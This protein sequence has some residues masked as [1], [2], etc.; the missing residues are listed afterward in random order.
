MAASGTRPR[1]VKLVTPT[2]LSSHLPGVA[3]AW[4]IMILSC[5][6]GC[7]E[8]TERTLP[9]AVT[10][11]E[12]T[13]VQ[14]EA[15]HVSVRSHP[16]HQGW[17]IHAVQPTIHHLRVLREAESTRVR[18]H[19][20]PLALPAGLFACP[21]SAWG[22][23]FSVLA[24]LSPVQHRKALLDYTITSCLMALMVVKSEPTIHTDTSLVEQREEHKDGPFLGGRAMLAWHGD[25]MIAVSYPIEEGKAVIRLRHLVTALR[26]A[27]IPEASWDNG[28]VDITVRHHD[29]LVRQWPV[30]TRLS[31]SVLR[32]PMVIRPDRWPTSPVFTVKIE[33][34]TAIPQADIEDRLRHALLRMG[35]TAIGSQSMTSLLRREL[36]EGLSG[37]VDD[38]TA[39]SPGHWLAPNVL[40]TMAAT[41]NDRATSVSLTLTKIQN[42]E[43]LGMIHVPAGPDDLSLA[44]DVAVAGLESML[45]EAKLVRP[46]SPTPSQR[47][48]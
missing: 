12:E 38:Q 24:P 5:L 46:G 34:G 33:Q 45:T 3:A 44:I 25:E 15:A 10:R 20:N 40:V 30:K 17:T 29:A 35:L 32:G 37:L 19:L 43:V 6:S 13:A 1:P 8:I 22:W 21:T 16:D 4:V 27:Q 9:G 26:Q 28:Q 11:S 42:R 48:R 7:I 14:N 18:Y 31:A 41:R 36:V 47:T 2:V 39:P 23:A